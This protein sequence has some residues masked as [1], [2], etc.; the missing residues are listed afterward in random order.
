MYLKRKVDA[1]LCAWKADPERKP[2]IIKGCRQ[3]GKTES[4]KQFAE[5]NY[6][7]VIEINFIR[8]EKYKGILADGYEA[9]AIIKKY[10][11]DRSVKKIHTEQNAAFL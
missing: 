10:F 6:E 11:P 3:V 4:V 8:D 5:K 9:S 2:L 1:F 7:S